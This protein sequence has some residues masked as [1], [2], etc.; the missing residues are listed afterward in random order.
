M[1]KKIK[2]K[3]HKEYLPIFLKGK[4]IFKSFKSTPKTVRLDIIRQCRILEV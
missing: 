3:V 2:D 1:C 4:E